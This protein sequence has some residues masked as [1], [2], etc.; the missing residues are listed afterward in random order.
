MR[1]ILPRVTP[2]AQGHA[3]ASAEAVRRQ[4]ALRIRGRP[5]KG[6]VFARLSWT[7][8]LSALRQPSIGSTCG[9]PACIFMHHSPA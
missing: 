1:F 2:R 3:R 7:F 6:G 5:D 4:Q 9:R 8:A